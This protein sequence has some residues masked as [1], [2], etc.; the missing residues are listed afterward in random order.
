[1]QVAM[2]V[3]VPTGLVR[4]GGDPLSPPRRRVKGDKSPSDSGRSV[5]VGEELSLR[6]SA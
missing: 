1:M 4:Q 3:T 2:G 5:V 6:S